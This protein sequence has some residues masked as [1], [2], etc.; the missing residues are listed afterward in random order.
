MDPLLAF[1]HVT[2]LPGSSYDTG[3]WRLDLEVMPGE[4]VVIGLE[5]R[6]ARLP[7]AD[8]ASGLVPCS[9]GRVS[10]EGMDWTRQSPAALARSRGR[11]GRTLRG[12]GWLP[13]LS[14]ADNITLGQRH[15]THRP[16]DEIRDEAAELARMFELPGLPMGPPWRTRTDDL[17][18]ASCVRA[19]LGDPLLLILEEPTRGAWPDIMA[20]LVNAV[21]RALGR[22]GGVLWLTASERVWQDASAHAT[23][24]GRMSGTQL[25]EVVEAEA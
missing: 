5:P 4:L 3:I 13:R 10:F 6:L 2:V 15:H 22:G 25:V 11:I 20:P 23:R 17:Q 7:I 14:V 8:A 21:R 24:C 1:D 9:E 12:E 16:D 18:R 19:F